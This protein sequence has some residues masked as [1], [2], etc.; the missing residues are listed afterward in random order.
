[1]LEYMYANTIICAP[2]LHAPLPPVRVS[3][4]FDAGFARS[5]RGK[6]AMAIPKNKGEIA[7]KISTHIF[8]LQVFYHAY[9]FTPL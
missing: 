7:H 9:F 3:A 5:P 4:G 6:S 8:S 2:W 1:M